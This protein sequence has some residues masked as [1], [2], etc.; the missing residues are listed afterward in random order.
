MPLSASEA[1]GETMITKENRSKQT[2]Q[3]GEPSLAIYEKAKIGSEKLKTCRDSAV[4]FIPV[5]LQ[6]RK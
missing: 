5:L 6:T 3:S 4:G 2:V 1:E